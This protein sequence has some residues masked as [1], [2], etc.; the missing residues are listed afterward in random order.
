V[1]VVDDVDVFLVVSVVVVVVT[2]TVVLVVDEVEVFVVVNH[3]EPSWQFIPISPDA[4]LEANPTYVTSTC[5]VR[6]VKSNV[7]SNTW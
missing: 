6:P 1:L 3:G 2:T 5:F 4:R 7:S